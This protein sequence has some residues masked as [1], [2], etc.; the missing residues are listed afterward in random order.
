MIAGESDAIIEKCGYL[1]HPPLGFVLSHPCF[2]RKAH[3][4][5]VLI[6]NSRI[7]QMWRPGVVPATSGSEAIEQFGR[8]NRLEQKFELVTEKTGFLDHV[9]NG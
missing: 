9:K 8:V 7:W 3:P 5:F 2:A 1:S 4:L 6:E